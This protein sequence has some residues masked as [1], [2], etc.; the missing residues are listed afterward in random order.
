MAKLTDAI[1]DLILN[2]VKE[3]AWTAQLGWIATVREDGAPNI[4]PKRSC[5]IY[6][7]TTLIWNENT[8][9]EIMKDIERGSKVAVAFAN[10]D[11]LDG[12]RF[13]GTAEVHKEGKYYDE[14]VE[15]AKGKMGTPKAAVV[16]HIE[17]VYT[18]KSG[19]N[20]GTRI[21]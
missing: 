20:A 11:K 2:P 15:W 17:E 7:D 3:G 8:A 13:V 19:P 18:L 5:R 16:F 14:V 4:G 12:Y 21:D 9:G 1:K 6:D 10:W